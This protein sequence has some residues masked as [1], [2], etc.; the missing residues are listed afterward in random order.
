MPAL[1]MI[2]VQLV[3]A[4]LRSYPALRDTAEELG[5]FFNVLKEEGRD[6]T[7]EEVDE[8]LARAELAAIKLS[9]LRGGPDL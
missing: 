4:L 8:W 9:R 6:A 1:V 3:I 7:P 2:L 5:A